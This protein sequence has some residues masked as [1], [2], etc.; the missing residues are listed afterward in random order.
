MLIALACIAGLFFLGVVA[1]SAI[2]WCDL[3]RHYR[4]INKGGIVIP[5]PFGDIEYV[6]GGTGLPVLV[7]HGS[8]GGYDQGELIS[9]VIL[10]DSFRWIAP[11]RFGYLKSALP[12]HAS[13]D[14]QAHAYACL[15]DHLGISQVG[16]VAVS[17]GGPSALLFCILHPDRV[18]SLTL[19]SCGVATSA[20]D[21]QETANRKG[22]L[23][24]WI[25]QYDWVYWW[26]SKIFQRSFLALMGASI[27][28]VS[29]LSAVQRR[30]L[31]QLLDFMNPV[32]PRAPGV[33]FDNSEALPGARI[34]AIQSPTLIVHAR[35]DSLQ[36]Y[37]NA[38]FAAAKISGARLVSFAE[39]GHVVMLVEQAEIQL[40]VQT[41]LREHFGICLDGGI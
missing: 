35:D 31:G 26:V 23:L 22:D 38:E 37:H 13:W 40:L 12:Q 36:L 1:C 30:D 8:G 9:R 32:V 7:I 34:L 33:T 41:H 28:V 27:G 5:S 4:R 3:R 2:C 20:S 21:A 6:T 29:R 19:L 11:S 14:D 17:H 39:G 18:S 24:K 25:Y 10:G 15:L 16:V